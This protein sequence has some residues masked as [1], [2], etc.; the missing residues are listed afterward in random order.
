M[1]SRR[2]AIALLAGRELLH[3]AGDARGAVRVL[4]D[5][6]RACAAWP[7]PDG[8]SVI[9]VPESSSGTCQLSPFPTAC[10]P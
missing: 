3:G 6:A 8:E 1:A 7:R 9:N 2:A 5:A 4:A 10:A